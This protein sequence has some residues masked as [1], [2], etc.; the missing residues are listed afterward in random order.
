MG[1][2]LHNSRFISGNRAVAHSVHVSCTKVGTGAAS[3]NCALVTPTPSLSRGQPIR[4]G[5]T[6]RR[7]VRSGFGVS[8]QLGWR[9]D[10]RQADHRGLSRSKFSLLI[11]PLPTLPVLCLPLSFGAC[12]WCLFEL[13]VACIHCNVSA[14]PVPAMGTHP[15]STLVLEETW[16]ES[17]SVVA[18]SS[19]WDPAAHPGAC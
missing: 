6:R 8:S 19:H 15:S 12:L 10:S 4:P 18:G 11:H 14:R 5:R 13:Q 17:S 2:C 9:E 7:P 1:T 3:H 16:A